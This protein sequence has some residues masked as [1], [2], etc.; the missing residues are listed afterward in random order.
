M[1]PDWPGAVVCAVAAP[2]IS[3]AAAVAVIRIRIVS[4]LDLVPL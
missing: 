4:L 3:R 1:L 2:V